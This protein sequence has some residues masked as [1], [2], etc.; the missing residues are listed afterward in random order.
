VYLPRIDANRTFPKLRWAAL[1]WLLIWFP[2]YARTWGWAN[3][4]HLCDVAL[5]LTCIGFWTGSALLLSSQ[6]VASI[7]LDLAWALDAGVRLLSGRHLF[8]GTEYL[9]DA[10]FPLLVRAMSLFHLVLPGLLV[11]AVRRTGY[12]RRAFL[13]QCG[14]A[15]GVLFCS[16]PFGPEANLNF[17]FK[18]PWGRTLPLHVLLVAAGLFGVVYLPA[19]L[20]LRRLPDCSKPGSRE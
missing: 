10:S 12:D 11:W 8:G 18:A 1:A 16:L 2:V 5:V 4:L 3:F 7:V 6:A 19:H 15:L 13:L 17:V 14:I 20:V 9:F